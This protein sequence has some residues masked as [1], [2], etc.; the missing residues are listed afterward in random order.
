MSARGARQAAQEPQE[1]PELAAEAPA[2]RTTLRALLGVDPAALGHAPRLLCWHGRDEDR[3]TGGEPCSW[4]WLGMIDTSRTYRTPPPLAEATHAQVPATSWGDYAGDA[5][6]RSNARALAADWPE[7]FV[8]VSGS[9][10]WECLAV[11]LDTERDEDAARELADI[12]RNLSDCYPLYDEEDYSE[13]LAEMAAEDWAEWAREDARQLYRSALIAAGISE[14]AAEAAANVADLSAWCSEWQEAG[15]VE[16]VAECAT[17]GGFYG[18]AGAV[19]E[20]AA[21]DAARALG[22]LGN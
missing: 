11:D 6:S 7:T 2:P 19:R 15:T 17:S 4:G 8:T 20:R 21:Q 10:S 18:I 5:V 12:L 22:V 3:P 13:L 14:D 16:Y 1:R 9:Y